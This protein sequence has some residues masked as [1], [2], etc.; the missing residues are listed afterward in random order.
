MSLAGFDRSPKKPGLADLASLIIRCDDC[1]NERRMGP[2]TLASFVERGL[3]CD[4]ALR[5][6]LVCSVCKSRGNWGRNLD[7][8]PTFRR[9]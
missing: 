6:K 3:H 5:P 4:M 9:A 7:L 2:P 1:G 8:I